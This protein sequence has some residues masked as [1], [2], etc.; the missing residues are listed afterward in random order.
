MRTIS[1][2]TPPDWNL[3]ASISQLSISTT[4][5]TAVASRWTTSARPPRLI[6]G[7]RRGIVMWAM[8]LTHHAHGTDNIRALANLALARGWLG[9]PGSGLLPI[10]G[11]SNVQGVG[12]VGVTPALKEAFASELERRFGI[13]VPRDP[14]QDTYASMEAAA[15]RPDRRRGAAGRQPLREQP[16]PGLGGRGVART[17]RCTVS[18]T[19][20]AQPGPRPR[21]RADLA[22]PPGARARRGAAGDHAG[23]DVQLRPASSVGDRPRSPGEMRSEVAM[24]SPSLAD[25]DAARR[26]VRLDRVRSHAQLRRLDR[27]RWFPATPAIARVETTASSTI[28]GRTF[29]DAEL[30]HRRREGALR[31]CRRRIPRRP[32]GSSA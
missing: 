30:R 32:P 10:R 22:R 19:T 16:G 11:H 13:T 4:W 7:A 25:A 31:V 12:S 14:G 2:G 24:C 17:S 6:S 29:H 28:E 18:L 1:N 23:V 15:R 20:Q 8:G 3:C 21:P 9:R 26:P 5:P 27:G